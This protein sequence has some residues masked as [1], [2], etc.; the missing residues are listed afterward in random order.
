MPLAYRQALY[1]CHMLFGMNPSIY[2][3]IQK[4]RQ[5][6]GRVL[7]SACFKVV[8]PPSLLARR[9]LF[10]SKMLPDLSIFAI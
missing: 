7:N 4:T 2:E 1:L 6:Q 3:H 10:A 5:D 9:G 8:F